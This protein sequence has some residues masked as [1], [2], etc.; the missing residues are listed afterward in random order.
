MG[1]GATF[2]LLQDTGAHNECWEVIEHEPPRTFAYRR[3]DWGSFIQCRYTLQRL[4][5]CTGLGL[6]V[7]AGVG[8]SSEPSPLLGQSAQR[9]LDIDLGRLRELLESGFGKEVR[10]GDAGDTAPGLGAAGRGLQPLRA[11][12]NRARSAGTQSMTTVPWVR[13]WTRGSVGTRPREPG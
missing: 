12:G 11:S 5:G 8:T 4:D 1:P 9:Q 6:E 10:D 7:H 13:P 3:L 2:E